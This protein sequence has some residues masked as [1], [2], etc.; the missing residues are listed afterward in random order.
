MLLGQIALPL[1]VQ[2]EPG[3]SQCHNFR[4]QAVP[5]PFNA[6]DHIDVRIRLAIIDSDPFVMIHRSVN[7]YCIRLGSEARSSVSVESK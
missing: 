1:A 5:P 7:L 3:W 6:G 2:H 4:T